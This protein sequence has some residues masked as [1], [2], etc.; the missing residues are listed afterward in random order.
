MEAAAGEGPTET[1]TRDLSDAA[2]GG[3]FELIVPSAEAPFVRTFNAALLVTGI[4]AVAALLLAAAIVA[5]RL[6][7]PLRDVAMAAR[8][9][10]GGDMTA[11]ARGGSDAESAEL[12]SAFNDMADRLE[13]SESLRRQAASDLAHDPGHPGDRARVPA[14]GDGRRR[15]AGRPRRAGAGAGRRGRPVEDDCPARRAH[16]GRGGAAQRRAELVDIAAVA[17]DAADGLAAVLRE[18]NV[19]IQVEGA[20]TTAVVDRGQLTGR[21]ATC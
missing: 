10:G 2:G 12:A 8:R 18:R 20:G 11:R 13:R 4:V 9:L 17:R 5:S 1:L 19:S 7:R 16:P 21:F 6:T 3:T 14:A 15:R